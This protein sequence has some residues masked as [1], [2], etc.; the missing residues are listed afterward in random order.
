[1]F[2]EAKSFNQPL[3]AW[4]VDKVQTFTGIFQK[5]TSFNQSLTAWNVDPKLLAK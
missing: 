2:C 4:D 3:N 1:M 5:A